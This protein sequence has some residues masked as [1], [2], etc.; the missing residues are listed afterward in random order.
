MHLPHRSCGRLNRPP[1]GRVVSGC[2]TRTAQTELSQ[3]NQLA[4]TLGRGAAPPNP[5]AQPQDLLAPRVGPLLNGGCFAPPKPP[6]GCACVDAERG[7]R[8]W[9]GVAE[10]VPEQR[11]TASSEV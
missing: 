5:P 8:V 10:L 3:H 6:V 2:E 11:C 1:D 7:R 4:S 9:L